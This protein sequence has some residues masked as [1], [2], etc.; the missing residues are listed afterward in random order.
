MT[1]R[2]SM[3]FV[4][5]SAMATSAIAQETAKSKVVQE[6]PI[7]T[8]VQPRDR[9]RDDALTLPSDPEN[10]ANNK[11]QEDPLLRPVQASADNAAEASRAVEKAMPAPQ[12][13]SASEPRA[14][15]QEDPML[16]LPA[17]VSRQ[18]PTP[19]DD[20]RAGM[21]AKVE[22]EADKETRLVPKPKDNAVQEDPLLRTGTPL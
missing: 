17:S 21:P 3:M 15:V 20:N 4:I 7:L 2:L 22:A 6:D 16:D 18:K 8:E 5:L 12:Q 1:I 13:D 11:V 9:D 19:R 10:A 14:K